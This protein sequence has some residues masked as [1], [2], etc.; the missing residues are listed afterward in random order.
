M[1]AF[2]DKNAQVVREFNFDPTGYYSGS[3]IQWSADGSQFWGDLQIEATPKTIYQVSVSDW[4]VKKFDVAPLNIGDEFE[5]NANTGQIA[6]S[7]Y[8]FL[9]EVNSNQQFIDNGTKVHLFLYDLNTQALQT[10][11]TSIA[12][13]FSPK[14][15]DNTIIQYNDP[16]G[17]ARIEY[18]IK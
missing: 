17:A 4:S 8:P 18:K 7:D 9:F 6:Y 1:L 13:L 10:I 14:W 12:R 2:I 11:A 15:L 5:L 16:N 3:P